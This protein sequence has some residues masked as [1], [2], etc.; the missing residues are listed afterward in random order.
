MIKCFNGGAENP[1]IGKIINSIIFV[2]F[3][4]AWKWMNVLAWKDIFRKEIVVFLLILIIG[5]FDVKEIY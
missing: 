5:D 3:F 1:I 2:V 4:I